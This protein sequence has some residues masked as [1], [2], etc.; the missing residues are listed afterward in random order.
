V[1]DSH[2]RTGRPQLFGGCYFAATGV[3]P[4]R[5][6]F[7]KSVFEKMQQMEDELEWTDEALSR[8]RRCA[9]IANTLLAVNGLLLLAIAGM[10]VY[11]IAM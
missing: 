6:S 7:V 4:D 5:Q 3:S 11:R 9:G 1:G 10:I 2:Q 8:D